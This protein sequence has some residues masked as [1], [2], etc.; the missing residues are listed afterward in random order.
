MKMIVHSEAGEK[1]TAL[2][3][4]RVQTV[5]TD[6]QYK[7]LLQVAKRK[8]KTLSA[9]VREAVE[10]E[11]LAEELRMAR[12]HAL[13]KLLSLDAP[14]SDWEKMEDEITRGVIGG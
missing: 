11:C 4:K 3:T 12:R 8:K 6:E 2:R 13:D 7:L 14:V 9:L 5:L 1:T 10:T